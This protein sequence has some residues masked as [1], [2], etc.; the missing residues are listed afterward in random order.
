MICLEI[1]LQPPPPHPL[2]DRHL[3][4]PP[5]PLL[6]DRHLLVGDISRGV[7]VQPPMSP[8]FCEA[9]PSLIL[10]PHLKWCWGAIFFHDGHGD[11][12]TEC[13]IRR[14]RRML[15]KKKHVIGDWCLHGWVF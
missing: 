10:A 5:P 3:D 11:G 12:S 14:T 9:V 7:R 4:A 6:G 15:S 13:A 1:P 2:G 8:G